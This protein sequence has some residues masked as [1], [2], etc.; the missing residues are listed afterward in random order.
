MISA[1]QQHV[2]AKNISAVV[3]YGLALPV[4]PS[5]TIHGMLIPPCYSIVTVEQTVS[6]SG[7][8][9]K[10]SSIS[11]EGAMKRLW[12]MH[13]TSCARPISNLLGI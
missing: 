2:K 1:S 6:T 4:I 7:D 9:E 5:G 13:S 12:E 8:N 3:A 10:S 11:L